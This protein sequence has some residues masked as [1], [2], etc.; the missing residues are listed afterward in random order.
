MPYD[1]VVSKLTTTLHLSNSEAGL[2]SNYVLVDSAKDFKISTFNGSA[3]GDSLISFNHTTKEITLGEADYKINMPGEINVVKQNDL[4]VSDVNITLA[5]GAASIANSG[6]LF[7]DTDTS[8]LINSTSDALTFKLGTASVNFKP[9]AGQAADAVLTKGD[10]EIF[11]TKTFKG[12]VQFDFPPV[13]GGNQDFDG[14]VNVDGSL[15]L[16]EN[17]T[18]DGVATFNG[19]AHFYGSTDFSGLSSSTITVKDGLTTTAMIGQTGAAAFTT[20]ETDKVLADEIIVSGA[21]SVDS[22]SVGGVASI[23]SLG[24]A[25]VSGLTVSGSSSVQDV[26]SS[27][28]ISAE[29]LSASIS[30]STQSIL[31]DAGSTQID[32]TGLATIALDVSGPSTLA[33]VS[34]TTVSSSGDISVG[35][36]LGSASLT[37]AS[38][39]TLSGA[40]SMGSTLAVSGA[41]TLSGGLTTAAISATSATLSGAFSVGNVSSSGTLSVSGASTLAAV[42]A[43]TVTASTKVVAPSIEVK[44]GSTVVAS[45]DNQGDMSVHSLM[46]GTDLS[47]NGTAAF[48]GNVTVDGILTVGQISIPAAADTL[49]LDTN[50]NMNNVW[51]TSTVTDSATVNHALV[52]AGSWDNSTET[53]TPKVTID[54]DLGKLTTVGNVEVGD[55]C[56]VSGDLTLT[57]EAYKTSG[58]QFFTIT[59]DSRVKT[60]IADADVAASVATIEAIRIRNFKY[61]PEYQSEFHVSDAVQIGVIADELQQVSSSSVRVSEAPVQIGELTIEHLK[62]VDMSNHMFHL[63][64]TV[65]HLL[66][67]VKTLKAEL[68]QCKGCQ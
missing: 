50:F 38:A 43:T 9:I 47:V 14:D 44:Q 7:K 19:L 53:F 8:L 34:A 54:G 24:A 22:L 26:V 31:V 15:T 11:G 10:Q 65:Q 6:L 4:V 56:K 55:D 60:E 64:Q 49:F 13:L 28:S 20:V 45:V 59:S 62:Q 32:S 58:S 51:S 68:A 5:D 21:A 66:G 48:D 17:L 57:G 42:S 67:E 18:V 37:V 12:P 61:I 36:N 63:I 52:Q 25:Q 40:V 2:T 1:G 46:V 33:S 27:G 16:G 41:A 30:V 29:T 35:G 39:S 3:V 23:S